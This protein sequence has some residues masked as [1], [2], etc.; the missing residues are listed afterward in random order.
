M[1]YS[2]SGQVSETASMSSKMPK[3]LS[4]ERITLGTTSGPKWAF[5]LVICLISVSWLAHNQSTGAMKATV[6]QKTVSGI[7]FLQAIEVV[8]VLM[9]QVG[10]ASGDS[11]AMHLIQRYSISR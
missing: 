6:S 5:S 11:M 7:A 9:S 1:G 8:I 10:Y 4:C 2:S 3:P